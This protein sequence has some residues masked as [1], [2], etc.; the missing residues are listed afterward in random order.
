MNQVSPTLQRIRESKEF[1]NLFTQGMSY[2]HQSGIFELLRENGRVYPVS[3]EAPNYVEYQAAL[4]SWSVGYNTAL[5]HLLRFREI[6]LDI[7]VDAS[8]VAAD[9]GAG[10]AAVEKGDLTVEELN[11]IR[12]GKP[13]PFLVPGNPRATSNKPGNGG[14]QAS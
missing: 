9:F 6:F 7:G 1:L 8:K 2:L 14:N 11:A 13:I 3:P 10:D 4:A 5:D 12:S